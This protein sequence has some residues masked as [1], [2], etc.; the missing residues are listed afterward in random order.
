MSG[1]RWLSWCFR[2]V[3]WL[4]IPHRARLHLFHLGIHP[5]TQW[6]EPDLQWA[7]Y[8][9]LYTSLFRPLCGMWLSI[10]LKGHVVIGDLRL[11]LE[12]T[13]Y[14]NHTG[15]KLHSVLIFFE[16]VTQLDECQ[17]W[18]LMVLQ[19]QITISC[20]KKTTKMYLSNHNAGYMLNVG[21]SKKYLDKLTKQTN[22]ILNTIS[23]IVNLNILGQIWSLSIKLTY[24]E[25][26][27]GFS[28]KLASLIK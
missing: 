11:Q 5:H 20:Q 14:T 16:S 23:Q 25:K 24:I 27:Q 1:H 26:L 19:R 28:I 17:W 7:L 15:N 2:H 9:W 21:D 18:A 12:T 22:F 4:H 10:W 6:R 8:C 3:G 13:H